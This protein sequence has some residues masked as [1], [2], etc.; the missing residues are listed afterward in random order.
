[1]KAQRNLDAP[2]TGL[3]PAPYSATSKG[4]IDAEK[5]PGPDSFTPAGIP[6]AWQLEGEELPLQTGGFDLVF[7]TLTLRH[8]C[9]QRKGVT[10]VRRVLAPGGRW[11]LADF[12]FMQRSRFVTRL[13]RRKHPEEREWLDGM[14]SDL[15]L[16]ELGAERGR[17]GVPARKDP[18]PIDHH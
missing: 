5:T 10:E 7:S 3:R 13:L 8:W 16:A 2:A 12:V 4:Q 1:V 18:A 6:S 11:L 9:D 15:G 17:P 14:L